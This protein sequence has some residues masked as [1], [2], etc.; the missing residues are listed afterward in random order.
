LGN[1]D[2]SQNVNLRNEKIE[3]TEERIIQFLKVLDYPGRIDEQMGK[4]FIMGD[5]SVVYPILYY[6]VINWQDLKIR[7]Y[8]GKFLVPIVLPEDLPTDDEIKKLQSEWSELVHQFEADYGT[9]EENKKTASSPSE[10]R[11]EIAQLEQEKDQL[12]TKIKL[13][14]QRE[15]SQNKEFADL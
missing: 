8:K 4:Q 12:V 5:R 15:I 11:K 2:A 14:Q 13:F 3:D 1:L 7:A 10:L 6:C 9:L